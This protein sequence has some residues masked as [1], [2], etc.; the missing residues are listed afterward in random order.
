MSTE[1]IILNAERFPSNSMKKKSSV[2][3]ERPKSQRLA[4]AKRIKKPFIKRF[5]DTFMDG[6][7]GHDVV[8][9]IIH[10]VVIPAAKTTIAE[11]VEGAIEMV[12]FGGE[13]RSRSAIRNK[14][15]SYVSYSDMYDKRRRPGDR[16]ERSGRSVRGRHDFTEYVLESRQEAELVLTNL[17]E[18]L[19]D[20]NVVSV[21]DLY[22]MLGVSTDYT[23][24][25]Y[26]WTELDN[27]SCVR[28][29]NGYILELPRPKL[30][31]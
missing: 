7:T 6:G 29:R 23:D 13:G 30:I 10:D 22:D 3:K 31:D 14:N 21:G 2:V 15:R 25:K 19:A 5:S 26:G 16:A 18:T 12:L 17:V 28:V 1:K 24:N 4:T 27:A 11:L 20:Y 8:N 9:Y